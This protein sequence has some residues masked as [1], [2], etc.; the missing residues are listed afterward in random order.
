M[1]DTSPGFTTQRTL[2]AIIFTDAVSFSARVQQDEVGTLKQLHRDFQQM[3]DLC[4]RHDG[5]VLKTT[6]DG[7]LMTFAS[8]VQAVGCALAMQRHFAAA[9]KEGDPAKLLQHR[10]GIHLGDILVQNQDVMGDGVNIASRLQAE[11]EPGGICISQTVYDVV[12][13]KLELKAVS[14]GPRE[15]K[16][17]TQAVPVYRILLEAQALESGRVLVPAPNGSVPATP[18]S[19]PAAPKASS[20]LPWVLAAAGAMALVFAAGVVF[21]R[22]QS[23]NDPPA[24]TGQPTPAVAGPNTPA[25]RG[26][27]GNAPRNA[28]GQPG[29][30]TTAPAPAPENVPAAAARRDLTQTRQQYLD[31]Y[32]FAGLV[33]AIQEGPEAAG[34]GRLGQQQLL[35]SAEQMQV[36][37]G[38][39]ESE[40]RRYS[41]QRPLAVTDMAGDTTRNFQVFL[42]PDNKVVT[43]V[44]GTLQPREWNAVP[45][46]VLGNVIVSALRQAGTSAPRDAVLGAQAFS[47]TYNLPAMLTAMPGLQPGGQNRAGRQGAAAP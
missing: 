38:W 33:K 11:A 5:A 41:R 7:L 45:P 46:A 19:A 36:L 13:N 4:A 18:I 2:A 28:G 8:A 34:A 31:T 29:V 23:R 44:N 22:R 27:R 43:S 39:L 30:A 42:T 16:N 24:P 9:A 6:G 17:I 32:D 26:Q 14:L 3:R 25:A 21:N 40:L 12:K 20:R 15:L 35:R 1:S 10:I 47:R 37:K